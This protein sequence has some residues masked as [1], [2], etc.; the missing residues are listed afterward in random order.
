MQWTSIPGGTPVDSDSGY[1]AQPPLRAA[2]SMEEVGDVYAERVGDEEQVGV[3]R[4][5]HRV[6]VSLNGAP[7]Q[8]GEVCQPLLG[9]LCLPP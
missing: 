7:L 1:A 6:L 8:S 3:L 5:P 4:V 9:E 2:L